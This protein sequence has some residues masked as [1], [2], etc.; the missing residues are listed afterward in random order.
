MLNKND[1]LIGPVLEVMKR[2]QAEREA[3]KTVNEKF[4][5][6]DR[7]ALPH[8]YQGE[9]DAAY[10]L[11]LSE[12][13]EALDEDE[14]ND[15]GKGK[16][17]KA[18]TYRHKTS[19]KEISAVKHP[20]KDWTCMSE[21][22]KGNQTKI[23]ANRNGKVDSGDF[24]L[25]KKGV[26]PVAEGNVDTVGKGENE[27]G[28]AVTVV[29]KPVATSTSSSGPTPSQQNALTNKIRKIMKEGA[30]VERMVGHIAASERASGKSPEKAKQIAWATANKRGM[31]N[32]EEAETVAEGYVAPS[33]GG[34]VQRNPV[35]AGNPNMAGAQSKIP[36]FQ[37]GGRGP[38]SSAPAPTQASN[39][40]EGDYRSKNATANIGSVSQQKGPFETRG[41]G[42][43][44][45]PPARTNSGITKLNANS[46]ASQQAAKP[47]FKPVRKAAPKPAAPRLQGTQASGL[48][49]RTQRDSAVGPSNRPAGGVTSGTRTGTTMTSR[50]TS[51]PKAP[52]GM[53]RVK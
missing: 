11:V 42:T 27:G 51:A 46:Q 33:M 25:L 31:L 36:A 39:A 50:P 30:K 34:V 17:E 52:A 53:G 13:V 9:W 5:I 47:A 29:K 19:G 44:S 49:S 20:G 15:K 2:N 38:A 7:K 21:E 14:M 10:Q 43:A 35:S 1:P 18:K 6:Q 3:V 28:S 4:G 12:G 40:P 37:I 23:D 41:K 45:L 26:R 8:E 48:Q 32:K 24:K 22:L 16:K